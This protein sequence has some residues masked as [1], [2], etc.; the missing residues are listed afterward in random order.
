MTLV[1][2]SIWVDHIHTPNP[3]LQELLLGE[4]VLMHPFVIGE[5]ACGNLRNREQALLDL[6]KL[7]AV[8]VASQQ[9]VLAL[10]EE[11]RLWGRG[12]GW[13]DVHLLAAA[14]ITG[15]RLWT[16]DQRLR[17][18]ARFLKVEV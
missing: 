9:E 15:C 8:T 14:L 4:R 16:L 17:G 10:I 13:I 2:T 11:R 18:V 3:G 1:D 5:I 6:R 12:V 7:P